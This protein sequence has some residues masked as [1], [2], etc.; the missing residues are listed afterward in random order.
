MVGAAFQRALFDVGNAA[1]QFF[2]VI[3][4]E[5]EGAYTFPSRTARPYCL[6]QQFRA[7][8]EYATV[9]VAECSSHAARQRGEIHYELRFDARSHG[10]GISQHH[11]A[12][13]VGMHDFDSGAIERGDYIILLIGAWTNMILRDGE[14]AID[15]DRQFRLRRREQNTERDR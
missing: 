10:Q 3:L 14:P 8:A 5:G 9:T 4:I 2:L 11:A 6:A 12:F 7:V 13:S 15:F 1:F